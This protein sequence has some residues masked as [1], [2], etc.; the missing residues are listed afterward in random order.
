M[1]LGDYPLKL[2]RHGGDLLAPAHRCHAQV[3]KCSQFSWGIRTRST[4]QSR[5]VLRGSRGVG[6]MRH[7]YHLAQI[8]R[9]QDTRSQVSSRS[10]L[11]ESIT[12]C[13]DFS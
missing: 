5:C 13:T 6:D 10:V 4:W 1:P 9:A 2:K 8:L 12:F 3:E 7:A 11:T